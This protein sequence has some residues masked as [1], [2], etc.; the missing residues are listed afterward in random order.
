MGEHLPT[1]PPIPPAI[2]KAL[3]Y[4]KSLPPQTSSTNNQAQFQ[5]TP[6]KPKGR[7]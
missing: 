4:L 5:A 2:Q 7:F 6:F 1:P 3:D